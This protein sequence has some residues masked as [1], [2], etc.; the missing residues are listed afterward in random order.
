V[1]R[2]TPVHWLLAGYCI[3][4]CLAL[5]WRPA[6]LSLVGAGVAVSLF[7]VWA[8]ARAAPV[9]RE[10]A[11][12]ALVA[13]R[14]LLERARVQ[15]PLLA[16]ALVFVITGLAV[17][18]WRV[19]AY[20]HSHLTTF[21]GRRATVEAVVV[22]L[23]T[24]SGAQ[25][26]VPVRVLAVASRPVDEP[27]HLSL[28][29]SKGVNAP[30]DPVSGLVEGTRV[31]LASVAIEALQPPQRGQF[32][33]RRYLERRGEHVAL[34]ANFGDLR[35]AGRRGG[36]AGLI[37]RLRLASRAHLRRGL[38]SPVRE[39]VQ[40][41][42]LGDDENISPQITD[43][44]RR[45]GLLHILAVSGENVVLLCAMWSFLF[46]L[47]GVGRTA[48]SFVLIP[49][50]I[51]YTVLTGASPSIVRA[52]VAGVLAL[53]A[54]LVSR[55]SDGW[56]LWFA[57]AAWLL[58]V[59]PNTLFDVSFQLTFAAVAGLLLL[60]RPLTDLLR[61]LPP[62][63]AEG[64]AVTTA[65]SI[66]TA[67]VS[68]FTFGSASVVGVPA[69]VAGA[70]VLGP[71][72]FLGM[73]SLLIGFV[74]APL[75]LPLNFVA[76]L[77][78]GFLLRVAAWFGSLPWAV[79]EWHGLTLAMA[80][81]IAAATELFMLWRLASRR[82]ETLLG[83]V[84]DARRRGHVVLG[85]ALVVVVAL[86]CTPLSPAAPHLPTLTFL[87]VGEGAAT[88][89][90]VPGGLTVLIDAG[91]AP[92]GAALRAHGVR[93]IDLLILSH[94]HADHTAGLADVLG[95]VPI[96]KAVLPRPPTP[97]ASLTKVAG[98][99]HAAGVPVEQPTAPLRLTAGSCEL[100]ILPTSG[101]SE[102]GNQGEND[103]ALVVLA[104]LAG[105]RVLVPGD[106][107]GEV[108][109]K[110]DLG[111]VAVAE[112]PHHGSRCGFDDRLLAALHPSL[113]VISVGPNRFGHPTREMLDLLA[114][115]RVRCL[116]TDA[117]GDIVLTVHGAQLA[118]SVRR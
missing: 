59:N 49:L 24:V 22:D 89:V 4:L 86:A 66:A 50:V 69:N 31:S 106:A 36:V 65:A 102:G 118:V 12:P 113:A 55:P 21:V 40:G 43:D 104:S 8:F 83:F 7:A 15:A 117:V 112:L 6:A 51:V 1:R 110:L 82:R 93:R 32:D 26:T 74:W 73:L 41:M 20:R 39:V 10:A 56:L 33:Y 87:D 96:A 58:T 54:G 61:G 23:P 100:T 85:S 60:S 84:A 114:G 76:G 108:L 116:R 46:T 95:A 80:L 9:A 63:I 45:S 68:V 105:Q 11:T 3:G 115:R 44:M 27:A 98:E 94:G 16:L 90:Q 77:F 75:C 103:C 17:G 97:I 5:V 101:S 25:M 57:P 2:A 92:L 67:P 38:R 62:S 72:M 52:G 53:L 88:L 64:V 42:V 19:D 13:A 48:R 70:F 18:Q 79:Y 47:A 111:G 34:R 109:A 99:L 29:L 81:T 78:T 107:E 30:T 35:V 71:I 14:S 28:K 37:D 91:P